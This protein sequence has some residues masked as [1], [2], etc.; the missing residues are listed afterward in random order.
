MTLTMVNEIIRDLVT[1]LSNLATRYGNADNG[2]ASAK[3]PQGVKFVKQP[4]YRMF[5]V[6]AKPRPNAVPLIGVRSI[7]ICAKTVLGT[8]ANIA[9]TVITS[10]LHTNRLRSHL[11]TRTVMMCPR[12][13]SC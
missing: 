8:V 13:R 11:M 1:K 12:T 6:S 2:H 5:I 10:A 7:R 3:Y 4:I 9:E